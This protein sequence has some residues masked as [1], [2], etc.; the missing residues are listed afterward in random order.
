MFESK[1]SEMGRGQ[2]DVETDFENGFLYSVVAL[3]NIVLTYFFLY[4]VV[5]LTAKT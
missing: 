1:N 3:Y 2:S 5:A 4:L